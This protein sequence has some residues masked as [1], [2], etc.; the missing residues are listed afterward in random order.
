M[1]RSPR[2]VFAAAPAL[3][4]ASVAACFLFFRP[5]SFPEVVAAPTDAPATKGTPV[6]T[7]DAFVESVKPVF[8]KYCVSCHNDKKM[9][10]GMTLEGFSDTAGARKAHDL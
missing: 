10:G 9:S 5:S 2:A 3:L 8:S 1:T 7:K 6:A 4:A